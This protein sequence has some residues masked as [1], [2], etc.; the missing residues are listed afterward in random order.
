MK[1]NI[2][3]TPMRCIEPMKLDSNHKKIYFNA[4]ITN[5]SIYNN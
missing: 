2:A 5:I 1:N 3:E 4:K